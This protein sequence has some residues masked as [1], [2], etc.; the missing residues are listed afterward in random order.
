[1]Y[2]WQQ[3]QRDKIEFIRF[4]GCNIDGMEQVS[5]EM[6]QTPGFNTAVSLSCE[7]TN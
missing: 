3:L 1:M 6:S 4:E 7:L 5:I 2:V